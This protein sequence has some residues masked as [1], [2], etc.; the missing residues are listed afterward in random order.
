VIPDGGD[1]KSGGAHAR[2]EFVEWLADQVGRGC[3][4]VQYDGPDP[5]AIDVAL[6]SAAD[7]V[8]GLVDE[9]FRVEWTVRDGQVFLKAWEDGR[10]KPPW[11]VVFK[12][13][14]LPSA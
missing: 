6:E 9:G 10:G 12:E 11:D 13:E 4:L 8:A 2:R 3:R 1:G 7:Q 14:P 5:F